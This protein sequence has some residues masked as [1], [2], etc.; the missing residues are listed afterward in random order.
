MFGYSEM[1]LGRLGIAD[2]HPKESLRFVESEFDAMVRNE[3]MMSSAIPCLRNDG[4]VFYA[5]ITAAD[6]SIN[7]RRFLVGFFADVTKRKRMEDALKESEMRYR[8]LVEFSP[9]AITHTDLNGKILMCNSQTALLHGYDR[10]EDLIGK[11]AFDLFPPD[12]LERAGANLQKTLAGTIVKDIEYRFVKKDGSQFHGELSAKAITDAAGK[13]ALFIAITRDI[14]ARKQAEKLLQESE[15]RFSKAFKITPYSYMIANMEDGAIIDVNDAFTTIS[16][17]TREEA[18]AGSTLKLNFWVDEEDRKRMMATLRDN[19]VVERMETRLRAKSGKIVT[20]LLFAH[21]IRLGR[22]SCILSIMEDITARKQAEAALRESEN[23]FRSTFENSNIGVAL[24]GLDGHYLLVNQALSDIFGYTVEELLSTGFFDITHPDDIER[25]R[26]IFL[27]VLNGKDKSVRFSKRYIHKDGHTIG[28]EISSST[29]LSA[30]GEPLYFISHISD[31]TARKLAE[32][33]LRESEENFRVLFNESPMPTLMS[34]VP[35]GRM[36]FVNKRLAESVGRT[37][38]DLIGKTPNELHLLKDPSDQERLTRL[39]AEKGSVD[40]VEFDKTYPDGSPGA[41]SISMR[42]VTVRGRLH[43]MTMIQDITE[44]KM[45]ENAVAAEK[46]RLAVTL[47]SIGDAVIATDVRGD[48]VL[49][50]KVAEDLTGWPLSEATE[51]PLSDIFNVVNEMTREHL[52]NPVEKVLS[53]GNIVELANHTLLISRDGTER[54]IADSGAPIKGINN[55]IIGVVLV[56]RDITEKQKFMDTIQ[57]TAKLDS[58]GILAGGIAHDFNNLLTGI[59]GYVDLARSVC[60]DTKISEYL[61]AMLSTMKR[62]KSLTLQLLTFAKG[63]SPVQKITPVISFIQ[64][65]ARFALSGSN[66]SCRFSLA[67]DLRP[68]NI[69]KNQIAQVIDNIVINA[70]QAMPDG[71]SIEIGAMNISFAENEHP[72]LVKGDYVKVSIKDFGIGIPKEIMPRIFDPFYTTKIKGHGL[73]LATCFSIIN[74]HGGCIDVESRPGKGSTFHI[75]LPASSEAVIA[76]PAVSNAHKGSGTIIVMDDEEVVREMF[77]QMLE[78]MGYAVVTKNGG[79]EA[80]DFYINEK[81]SRQF[82]AMIFDLT[83]PGGMGGMEAVKEIRKLNKEIPIFVASGYA[84]NSALKNPVEY[85]FTASISKPFTQSE[86]SEML[87][88]YLKSGL[89][90][91]NYLQKG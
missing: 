87:N 24:V 8:A 47:H 43:C 3:K 64:E 70:Q 35:S 76:D 42:L 86:L 83:I 56:F 51:K 79:R 38:E 33:A 80:V 1:E 57:R 60:K 90:G 89:S 82:A 59:Y 62:A 45:A 11:T 2:I 17:F 29:I 55:K 22:K 84:D 6:T 67:E 65:T 7:G 91:L 9:D 39:I 25:S 54:V 34:E 23:K 73:G 37:V 21:M 75:C 26:T 68:C 46:E 66:I 63:G 13:P 81:V 44:R 74:R 72:P 30:A 52:E 32:D 36:N 5:D 71:G 19:G 40:N 16:G 15:E 78:S 14:T 61:E 69:D 4:T 50:N 31:I 12:E 88:K 10:A 18:L 20:A 77:R 53:S 27:Q 85:G 58:L 49:M 48:I 41:V 28:A